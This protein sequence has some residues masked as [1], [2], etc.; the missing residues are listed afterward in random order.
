MQR[1]AQVLKSNGTE[2]ELL[3]SFLD[4]SP[5]DIDLEE[6]VFVYFDG[7]P[8]PFYFESFTRR[9]T[10]R[11]LV[12]LTGVHSLKDADELSGASLYAN[13][14]EEEEEEEEDLTGWTVRDQDGALVGTVADYED[15]PG[16]TCL[17]I[18]RPGGG[19]VLVPFHEDLVLSADGKT[20]TLTLRIPEGLLSF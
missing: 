13:Y 7:L 12:R 18:R 9:G 14:F 16:N 5:E 6:P 19:E 20:G 2:G 8:V 3:V 15:I 4:V 1:I 17:W 10:G 11:A